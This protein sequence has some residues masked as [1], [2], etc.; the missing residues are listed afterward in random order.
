[1]KLIV[2]LCL[3]FTGFLP[4]FAQKDTNINY[5]TLIG[6]NGN[7]LFTSKNEYSVSNQIKI[8]RKSKIG[9]YRFKLP[10]DDNGFVTDAQV[11]ESF[12]S[13]LN[14]INVI[15]IPQIDV[16]TSNERFLPEYYSNNFKRGRNFCYNYGNYLNTIE[17]GYNCDRESMISDSLDGSE[18]SHYNQTKTQQIMA[19]LSGFI[20]GVHSLDT[21]IRVAI[22]VSDRHYF[23]LEFLN[24]FKVNYNIIALHFN[25]PEVDLNTNSYNLWNDL[26]FIKNR[27]N[28]SLWLTGF[29]YPGDELRGK[30]QENSYTLST[31]TLK[32]LV[33]DGII[34]R[35]FIDNNFK[36]STYSNLPSIFSKKNLL[37]QNID[38]ALTIR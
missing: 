18:Q 1:M 19:A 29:S 21:S 22:A 32:K 20:D 13:T 9:S 16:S 24:M 17:L 33:V 10:L 2:A 36:K 27:Y 28:K 6:V 25:D 34:D 23:F 7:M 5:R 11:L 14:K 30:F 31:N 4:V 26:Q 38:F 3:L 15:A 12:F 8:L 37:K 35:L